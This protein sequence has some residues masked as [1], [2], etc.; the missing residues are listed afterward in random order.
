MCCVVQTDPSR[1]SRGGLYIIRR[2]TDIKSA[3]MTTLNCHCAEWIHEDTAGCTELSGSSESLS[4]PEQCYSL[5]CYL[6]QEPCL[7]PW[8]QNQVWYKTSSLCGEMHNQLIKWDVLMKATCSQE[9]FLWDTQIIKALE[10]FQQ[11]CSLV[12]I[13]CLLSTILIWTEI[14]QQICDEL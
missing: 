1:S 7:H 12:G 14:C 8:R 9:N 5:R 13:D 10:A 2:F 3:Q 11:R 4:G 6:K